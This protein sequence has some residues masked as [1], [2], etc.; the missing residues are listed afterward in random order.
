VRVFSSAFVGNDSAEKQFS[1]VSVEGDDG[2]GKGYCIVSSL[3]LQSC[4]SVQLKE[5]MVFVHNAI[6]FCH[7]EE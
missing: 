3:V 2:Y 7:K 6:L 4:Q 5:H 1:S